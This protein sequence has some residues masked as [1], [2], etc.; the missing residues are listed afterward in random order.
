MRARKADSSG[1]TIVVSTEKIE[2][3]GSREF[4]RLQVGELPA[5]SALQTCYP[6]QK[7]TEEHTLVGA[8]GSVEKQSKFTKNGLISVG[9]GGS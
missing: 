9:E 4:A 7:F 8:D 5:S 2:W 3:S 1:Q 6:V